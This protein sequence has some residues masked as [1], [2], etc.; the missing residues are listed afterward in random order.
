MPN[1]HWYNGTTCFIINM[2]KHVCFIL[3][4]QNIYQQFSCSILYSINIVN[5]QVKQV[6]SIPADI[7]TVQFYSPEYILFPED[8]LD[9]SQDIVKINKWTLKVFHVFLVSNVLTQM[10]I[11]FSC[12]CV[13]MKWYSPFI[14]VERIKNGASVNFWSKLA[15][16]HVN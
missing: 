4:C 11:N 2:F 8:L 9:S 15:S 7:R 14:I 13:I 6:F 16:L 5:I 12:V 10:H 1:V 3:V